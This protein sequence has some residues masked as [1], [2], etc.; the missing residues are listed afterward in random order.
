MKI[1]WR[2][3]FCL[4]I[5]SLSLEVFLLSRQNRELK[6]RLKL[7]VGNVA[8]REGDNVPDFKAFSCISGQEINFVYDGKVPYTLLF[9]FSISCGAC[10][11]NL[12]NWSEIADS[13]STKSC[14][15][16]GICID[17]NDEMK[18]DVS[19]IGMNYLVYVPTDTAFTKGYK[20]YLTPQ[21]ILIDAKGRIRH[22]WTGILEKREKE[23]IIT[24][25]NRTVLS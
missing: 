13:L 3:I 12:A 5:I 25:L 18:N 21:T 7:L 10:E 19:I 23:Q 20:P 24:T 14:R 4:A 8:I 11:R 22:V 6:G 1:S 16:A 17:L 15:V 9:V 2:I